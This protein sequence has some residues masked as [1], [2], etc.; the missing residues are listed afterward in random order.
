MRSALL[1]MVLAT[2]GCYFSQSPSR[3]I[4]TLLARA[5][6]GATA[7]CL[8]IFL[9]GLLDGAD[10]FV[11]HGMVRDL[12]ASGA[13]CD[14]AMVELGY[15]YYFG[16]RVGDTLYEDVLYPA[17]ARGYEE[18]WVVGISLGGLGATLLAREHGE[19]IAGVI[20][21]SPFLGIDPTLRDV[22]TRR[23]VA[24]PGSG[25]PGEQLGAALTADVHAYGHQR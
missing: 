19:A 17:L 21:L 20:L 10:S 14:A 22:V 4:P 9:P 2:S 3:P 5:S 1:A 7:R 11:E 18:V 15:R 24:S 25:P 13:P 6:S 16:A 12:I 8:V 23:C